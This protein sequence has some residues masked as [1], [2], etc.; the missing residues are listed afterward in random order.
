EYRIVLLRHP[1]AWVIARL[2]EVHHVKT[3][4]WIEWPYA[5]WI[6]VALVLL[7]VL[8]LSLHAH[9]EEPGPQESHPQSDGPPGLFIKIAPPARQLIAAEVRGLPADRTLTLTSLQGIVNQT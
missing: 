3:A 5:A 2:E 4:W 8:S 1:S 7:T 6:T 9:A